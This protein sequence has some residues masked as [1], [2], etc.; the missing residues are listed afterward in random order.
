VAVSIAIVML[1]IAQAQLALSITGASWR[2]FAVAHVPG[3]VLGLVTLAFLVPLRLLGERA[4]L[5]HLA[6]LLLLSV[7]SAAST[8][9]GLFYMPAAIR[10]TELFV[11][12]SKP[13]RRFPAAMRTPLLRILGVS[14]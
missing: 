14:G 7:T 12:L 1:F 5:P 11:Q 9:L 6:I 3:L 2:A 8:S 4:G 10:P 13:L